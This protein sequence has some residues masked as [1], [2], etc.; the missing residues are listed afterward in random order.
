M[1]SN[2][3]ND[4]QTAYIMNEYSLYDNTFGAGLLYWF[5][6]TFNYDDNALWWATTR[7]P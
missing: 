3:T 1:S 7:S 5:G 4:M 2:I 6:Y